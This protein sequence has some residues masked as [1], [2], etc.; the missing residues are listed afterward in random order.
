MQLGFGRARFRSK[1]ASSAGLH[2][3]ATAAPNSSQFRA[4]TGET[5]ETHRIGR[6]RGQARLRLVA[7]HLPLDGNLG[8][9][10][11]RRLRRPAGTPSKAARTVLAADSWRLRKKER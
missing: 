7:A 5:V 11:G 6:I 1:S 9:R 10:T 8:S 2:P 4:P 3:G